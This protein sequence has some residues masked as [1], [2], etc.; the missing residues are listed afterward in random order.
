M[1]CCPNVS[2]TFSG[3]GIPTYRI[4]VQSFSATILYY[5]IFY[6]AEQTNVT[7]SNDHV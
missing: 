2:A 1:S 3:G 6:C 7:P 5:F 4:G